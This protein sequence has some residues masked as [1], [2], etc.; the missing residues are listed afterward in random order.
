MTLTWPGFDSAASFSGWKWDAGLFTAAR[1]NRSPVSR[2]ESTG[3]LFLKKKLEHGP[4]FSIN[5][6]INHLVN[7]SG[8]FV[9]LKLIRFKFIWKFQEMDQ[10]T[11]MERH[12][13]RR[14]WMRMRWAG[15]KHVQQ[16]KHQISRVRFVENRL[17]ALI[18]IN[19]TGKSVGTC[20]AKRRI[21]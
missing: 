21:N 20:S 12:W 13:R 7:T 18:S 3:T 10:R 15:K 9:Q 11:R 17:A 2:N 1:R 5:K 6:Q 8:T 19:L 16:C 14:K 4:N